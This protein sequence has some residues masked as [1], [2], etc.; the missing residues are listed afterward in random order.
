MTLLAVILLLPC[1][2]SAAVTILPTYRANYTAAA[3][4]LRADL[5]AG[6]DKEV[7][8]TSTRLPENGT[9]Y[10]EAGT[11]VEMQIRFFK[12]ITVD[13]S[14]G[15]MQLKVWLRMYW[16]DTRL[17]WDPAEYDNITFT[18]LWADPTPTSGSTEL[19]VPDVQPYNARVNIVHALDPAHA[20]VEHTGRVFLSR[21]GTL[22]VLCKFSGLVA[23][24][25]DVL[26]CKI[27]FGG[28]VWSGGH[29]GIVLHN[30]GYQFSQQEATSGSTYQE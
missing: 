16:T 3:T 13:A 29:Q 6:Y 2:A 25:F 1:A 9:V 4:R 28:W 12:V 27:E 18:S 19:W 7:P 14:Q 30:G 24:P 10:S 17:S 26:K 5:L 8:P 21:P 11:D 20:R 22:D 15:V 23:F